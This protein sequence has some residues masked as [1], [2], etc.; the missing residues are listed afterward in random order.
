MRKPVLFDLRALAALSLMGLL[1]L[2]SCSTKEAKFEPA[3]FKPDKQ[4]I[5]AS[6]P[7]PDLDLEFSPP[8]E[9]KVMDSTTLDNLRRM[10]ARTPLALEFYPIQP[11]VG[12]SDS[13][14]GSLMYIAQVEAE[15]ASLTKV[16]DRG[17]DYLQSR[18][19]T[20]AM[21]SNQ[22]LI[23]GIKIYSFLLHS[24]EVVNYKLIGEASPGKSFVIE[25][26]V[27]AAQYPAL[28]G[29]LSASLASFKPIAPDTGQ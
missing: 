8:G 18:L 14:T 7:V 15:G 23:N 26:V 20:A 27:G 16:A 19:G 21:T 24:T 2:M 9:W 12:A 11:L 13:L 29:S 4:L 6:I 10:L 3:P 5:G 28:E 1:I 25:Y 22:Y 17:R